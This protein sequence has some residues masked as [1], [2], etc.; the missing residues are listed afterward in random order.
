MTA[1]EDAE[2]DR[3]WRGKL[4]GMIDALRGRYRKTDGDRW[5]WFIVKRG[6]V[7]SYREVVNSRG[8]IR[9]ARDQPLLESQQSAWETEVRVF[10][11]H[12]VSCR[13]RERTL[14]TKKS[15]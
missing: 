8:E 15:G 14:A 12:G 9:I 6:A 11:R 5:E 7:V 13:R 3:Q 4:G 2:P 10:C 1:F